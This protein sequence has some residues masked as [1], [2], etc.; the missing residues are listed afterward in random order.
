VLRDYQS[1]I[2]HDFDRLAAGRVRLAL[3]T[4]LTGAAKTVMLV[5]L[6]VA[7]WQPDAEV[8]CGGLLLLGA[9]R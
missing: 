5:A 7:A 2:T 8:G 1:Q 6:P 4:A 3:V 9:P